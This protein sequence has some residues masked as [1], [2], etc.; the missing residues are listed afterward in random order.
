M[1]ERLPQ[2]R[3]APAAASSHQRTQLHSAWGAEQKLQKLQN[4][5]LEALGL[6]G[7]NSNHN[8]SDIWNGTNAAVFHHLALPPLARP[9]EVSH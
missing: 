1:E 5:N 7:D 8:D 4:L 9:S 3:Y 6:A 2:V